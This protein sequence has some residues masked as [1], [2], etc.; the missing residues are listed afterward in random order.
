M[1]EAVRVPALGVS[2]PGAKAAA[3]KQ[4]EAAS[5][6]KG[7]EPVGPGGTELI[8]KAMSV[9][10]ARKGV[11]FNTL[12]KALAAGHYDM[13]KNIRCTKLGLKKIVSKGTLVQTKSTDTSSSFKLN[14]K[15][16][17][18][19]EKAT[20]KKLAAKSKKPA[21]KK[22][23]KVAAVK[24]SPKKVKKPAAAAAKKAAKSAKKA[25]KAGSP[26]KGGCPKKAVKS[27]AKAKVVKPKV[28]KPK[29]AEPQ[30]VKAKK[31]APK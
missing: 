17:K 7:C 15:L 18:T 13:E 9:S 10:T 6:S 24:K 3:K 5:A 4:K 1:P 23:K 29:P 28:G 11:F 21:A 2:V 22:P 14:K 20:K 19:N 30:A 31:A 12:K 16:G 25:K 26:K 27:L 8:T